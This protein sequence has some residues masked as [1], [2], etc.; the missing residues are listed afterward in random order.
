MKEEFCPE[1]HGVTNVGNTTLFNSCV[2]CKTCDKVY[3][4]ELREVPKKWFDENYNSDS[5][6]QIKGYAEFLEARKK[7]NQ[8]DLIKLG[9][10]EGEDQ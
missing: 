9:Y 7:V 8:Q 10:L 2:F 6:D 4:Y 3:Q 1:G 5:F